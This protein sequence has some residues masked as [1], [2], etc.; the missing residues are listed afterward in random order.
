MKQVLLLLAMI[1]VFAGAAQAQE[2][3]CPKEVLKCTFYKNNTKAEKKFVDSDEKS[4]AWIWAQGECGTVLYSDVNY[5]DTMRVSFNGE[6]RF[7][8]FDIVDRFDGPTVKRDGGSAF[9]AQKN[10]PIYFQYND[11]LAICEIN[12]K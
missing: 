7:I 8:N 12:D 2:K 9:V 11:H 4:L 5:N 3:E 1:F 6:T 10:S